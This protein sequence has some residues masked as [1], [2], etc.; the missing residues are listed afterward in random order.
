MYVEVALLLYEQPDLDADRVALHL[1]IDTQSRDHSIHARASV[2]TTLRHSHARHVPLIRHT[3]AH[4]LLA[5]TL[6]PC[7]APACR[8]VH[9]VRQRLV[10]HSE[11]AFAIDGEA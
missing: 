2:R 6:D 3:R 7:S 8:P 11:V 5:R 9:D 1:L 4:T 10:D